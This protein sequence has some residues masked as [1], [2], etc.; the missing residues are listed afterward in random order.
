MKVRLAEYED[1]KRLTSYDSHISEQELENSIRMG[2]VYVAE[3]EGCFTGWLRYN[4][5]WDNTPFLN[6]LYVLEEYRGQGC[7]RQLVR[8]WEAE[9]QRQGY[10]TLL[11]STQSD[12]Y[13]QHFYVRIGYEA[14]GGF[15][16][17]GDPYEILFAK[18]FT[19]A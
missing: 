18:R 19:E 13:A 6:L 1:R 4:L 7:G 5:F 3:N 8:F 11:T 16:L 12:E 10:Q 14:V 2:R 9:M 17:D 15:R